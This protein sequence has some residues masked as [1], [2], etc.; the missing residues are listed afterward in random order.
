LKRPPLLPLG[1]IAGNLLV[2]AGMDF[3]IVLERKC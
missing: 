1:W 2:R 3:G